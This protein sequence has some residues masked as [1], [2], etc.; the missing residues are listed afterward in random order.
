MLL[1]SCIVLPSYI[2]TH[3]HTRVRAK[4]SAQGLLSCSVRGQGCVDR[5]TL[6]SSPRESPRSSK[7]F[8]RLGLHTV[9]HQADHYRSSKRKQ[10]RTK[11]RWISAHVVELDL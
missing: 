6:W 8:R 4:K 11:V 2:H 9:L 5:R 3:T 7:A 1:F 10:N